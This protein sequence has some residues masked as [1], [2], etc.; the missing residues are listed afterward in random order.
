MLVWHKLQ[1]FWG[2]RLLC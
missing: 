1:S 2:L